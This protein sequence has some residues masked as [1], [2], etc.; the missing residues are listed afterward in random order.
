[1]KIVRFTGGLGNQMFQYAFYKSLKKNNQ[2]V[3]A[4]L[5]PFEGHECHNGFE[6][7]H[8]FGIELNKASKFI[9]DL[10]YT[11]NRK[12]LFRKLRRL[13]IMKNTHKEELNEFIFDES[14]FTDRKSQIY[15]GYWQHERYLKD[16][17]IRED[18]V[19]KKP[20]STQNQQLKEKIEQTSSVS[21]HVRRGDYINHPLLG[22]ICDLQYYHSAIELIQSKVDNP[23]YYIFSNDI[24]WCKESLRLKNAIYIDWNTGNNSSIDLQL[25]SLCK[26]QIIA[27]SSFSWWA[28]WLN[29]NINKIIIAPQIWINGEKFRNIDIVP[30]SWI[31]I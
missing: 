2:K 1:M 24:H 9:I 6:L 3:L 4:D 19:F 15:S 31:K 27:N 17:D 14:F 5:S 12:W 10:Y 28:A 8:V 25:M 21:I 30:K 22:N 16:I 29:T 23:V 11:P 13:L 7:N 26:H 20:L 18:F